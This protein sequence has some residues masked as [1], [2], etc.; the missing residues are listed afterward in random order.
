MQRKCL[1]RD[2]GFGFPVSGFRENRCRLSVF[3]AGTTHIAAKPPRNDLRLP[4]ETGNRKPETE[5]F[6]R[7]H[8]DDQ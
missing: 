3:Q 1:E 8:V 7:P 2:N 4:P 6:F 5:L